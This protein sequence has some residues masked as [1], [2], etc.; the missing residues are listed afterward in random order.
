MH[1]VQRHC[2]IRRILHRRLYRRRRRRRRRRERS[3]GQKETCL[4]KRL[5][6]AMNSRVQ[7]R[8]IQGTNK[9]QMPGRCIT[10]ETLHSTLTIC[11]RPTPAA[12]FETWRAATAT[13]NNNNLVET[14]NRASGTRLPRRSAQDGRPMNLLCSNPLKGYNANWRGTTSNAQSTPSVIAR[15]HNKQRWC[16]QRNKPACSFKIVAPIVVS[17]QGVHHLNSE[18]NLLIHL[19]PRFF[20]ARSAIKRYAASFLLLTTAVIGELGPRTRH[21]H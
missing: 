17:R 1:N 13:L 6:K 16:C 2:N 7:G 19:V 18:L 21:R 5:A 15:V 9:V 8:E 11:Q 3:K 14:H 10:T 4:A 12:V 20:A